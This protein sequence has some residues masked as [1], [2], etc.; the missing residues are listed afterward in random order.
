MRTR[1]LLA[2]LAILLTPCACTQGVLPQAGSIPEITDTYVDIV[3]DDGALL[4]AKVSETGLVATCGF[5]VYQRGSTQ[6]M[7]YETSCEG[8]MFSVMADGLRPETGYEFEAFVEN[9]KGLIVKS[10]RH[11]FTTLEGAPG[12]PSY[13]M[14]FE[15]FVL[16]EFDTDHDGTLS[17]EE[18]L[19]VKKMTVYTDSIACLT[20]LERFRNLET[21]LCH[22]HRISAKSL[23]RELDLSGNPA[24]KKVN[25]IRN[26]METIMFP[27]D[28]EIIDLNIGFNNFITL[29]LRPLRN[30][31][32]LNLI[33]CHMLRTV[34]L[35]S[36]Q[37]VTIYSNTSFNIIREDE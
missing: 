19:K 8:N 22:P 32:D 34:Y 25:A 5:H 18:A 17:E 6:A 1:Y 35:W 24:L 33:G 7:R 10:E 15:E 21:L 9:G 4:C 13:S 20:H 12:E 29:D 14:S 31:K 3:S 27:Q 30:L 36:W 26:D 2:I 28:S 16:R 11:L 23:M 37:N